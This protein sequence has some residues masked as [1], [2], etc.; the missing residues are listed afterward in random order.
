MA[1]GGRSEAPAELAGFGVE[2][3]ESDVLG[4]LPDLGDLGWAGAVGVRGDLRERVLRRGTRALG[5][6]EL[7]QIGLDNVGVVDGLS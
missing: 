2:R 7:G 5:A 4:D 1:V 6:D 3:V